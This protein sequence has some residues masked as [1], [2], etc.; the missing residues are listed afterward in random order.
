MLQNEA[1]VG[2]YPACFFWNK[3]GQIP[4]GFVYVGHLPWLK[5]LETREQLPLRGSEQI[6]VIQSYFRGVSAWGKREGKWELMRLPELGIQ[7]LVLLCRD[8]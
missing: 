1:K 2:S 8:T 7:E 5:S 3:L 4:H 6:P